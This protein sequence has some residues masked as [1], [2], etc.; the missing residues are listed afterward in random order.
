MAVLIAMLAAALVLGPIATTVDEILASRPADSLLVPLTRFETTHR[1]SDAAAAALTLGQLHYARGEYRQAAGDFVRATPR[2][3][4]A[5][6]GEAHYWTGLAWLGAGEMGQARAAFEEAAR[7]DSPRRPESQ[8]GV[9]LCWEAARRPERALET[10]Q[11]LLAGEPGEAGPAALEHVAMLATRLERPELARRARER[12]AQDYPRS[13]EAMR[14]LR[15]VGSGPARAS[16]PAS[17][18]PDPA[19]AR[20]APPPVAAQVPLAVQIGVFREEARARELAERARRGGF[21]PARVAALTDASGKLFAV[22]VGVYATAE[23]ARGAG[24][25][26]G[27]ALAVS[28]RV[29]PVP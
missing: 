15:A 1:G 17:R 2:S 22:R 20:L 16:H 14:A 10:L 19:A 23:D 29:V 25:R 24:D 5:R 3:G 11:T 28:W 13:I 6:R 4:A 21:G 12:L 8:L 9:A 7:S 27:R 26:L 18:P